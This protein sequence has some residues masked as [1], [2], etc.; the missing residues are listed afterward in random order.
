MR[1]REW[2]RIVREAIRLGKLRRR[3]VSREQYGQV[4]KNR[5]KIEDKIVRHIIGKD[6]GL[7]DDAQAELLNWNRLFNWE[8]H[9]GLFSMFRASHRVVVE[10]K[11]DMVLGPTADD[12]NDAMYMNRCAE[13]GWMILRLLPFMRRA[14]TPKDED[15]DK[16]WKLLDDSFK[17][18]VD[19]LGGL[20][21][22]IAPAFT[23]M[24]GAKFNFDSSLY[25][26]E[27]K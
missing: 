7:S 5:M 17:M 26:F 13:I 2:N 3:T 25:Y 18:M 23:E 16:K 15:W 14:E 10:K 19:G 20:G 9:R 11:F 4:I 27:K 8:A 24:I 1:G 12:L 22:K 6:S 21:K